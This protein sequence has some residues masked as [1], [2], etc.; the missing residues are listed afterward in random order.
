MWIPIRAWIA[1]A[2][3]YPAI[4]G[5]PMTFKS[6]NIFQV[7]AEGEITPD[8]PNVFADFLK[9]NSMFRQTVTFNSPG[10]N[11]VAG[12]DLGRAIRSAGWNT[13]VG[14][15]GLSTLSWNPGECDSACTFAF[16]G[17]RTRSIAAG[18][19]FGVHRF[20]GLQ[21]DVEQITQQLAG[22]LVAYIRE[23]GVSTE[24]Y[25]LM[26]Q[27]EPKQVKYLDGDTLARLRITTREFVAAEM[28]DENGVPVVHVT[29]GDNGGTTYGHIDFYCNGPRL[30]ARVYFPPLAGE[31]NP[32]QYTLEWISSIPP[33]VADRQ[34]NIPV[35]DYRYRGKDATQ[36]WIDVNVTPALLQNWIISATSIGVKLLRTGGLAL[37][38][39]QDRVGSAGTP[40]PGAFRTLVQTMERSCH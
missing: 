23:M 1:F 36:I 20:I 9:Q 31:F 4:A 3:I 6:P 19:R 38:A 18:S 30:L 11:L 13:N 24:M 26:T 28:R 39:P 35:A 16:L 10:G 40:L 7:F 29:D 8:T 21:G 22:D 14:T 12:L 34:F 25:T 27:A 37:G 5:S 15:P 17:G 32:A 2:T 33:N